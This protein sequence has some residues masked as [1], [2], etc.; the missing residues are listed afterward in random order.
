MNFAR[1][2]SLAFGVILGAS[3]AFVA[4]PSLAQVPPGGTIVLGE[5]NRLGAFDNGNANLLASQGPYALAQPAFVQ[6]LSFWVGHA[7]GKLLLGLYDAGPNQDCRGGALLAETNAFTPTGQT[8]NTQPVTVKANLPAGWYCLAYL[9]SDNA[10]SFRKGLATGVREVNYPRNFSLGLPAQFAAS[11]GGDPYHWMFYATLIAGSKPAPTPV[12]SFNPPAPSI[13]PNAAAGTL[14]ATVN[15]TM[16][17]GSPFTGSLAF[18]PY[19]SDNGTFSLNGQQIVVANA[20]A[21]L[22]EANTTQHVTVEAA[23]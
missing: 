5:P 21:L 13:A 8:W 14:V 19:G 22:A 1:L 7:A 4:A 6:S 17:D 10:L 20:A 9:P 11:T 3:T 18:A 2:G 23:Q 15:V 12:I 16:S